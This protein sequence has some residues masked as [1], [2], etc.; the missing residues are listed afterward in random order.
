MK[1]DDEPAK[2]A[3]PTRGLYGQRP[4]ASGDAARR[5]EFAAA[6]AMTPRERMVRALMLGR[7]LRTLAERC[8][9]TGSAER[10]T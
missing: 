9:G 4:S 5:A 7:E 8:Q 10:E 6:W 2:A 3:S 1:P